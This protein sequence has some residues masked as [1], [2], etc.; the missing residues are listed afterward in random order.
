[1]RECPPQH[2]NSVFSFLAVAQLSVL[3]IFPH[4]CLRFPLSRKRHQC[5]KQRDSLELQDE[6][7][8]SPVWVFLGVKRDKLTFLT[9]TSNRLFPPRA[10]AMVAPKPSCTFSAQHQ[11]WWSLLR[12]GL[13]QGP[14]PSSVQLGVRRKLL[15]TAFPSLP[16]A[17]Q[18]CIPQTASC[19]LPRGWHRGGPTAELSKSSSEWLTMRLPLQGDGLPCKTSLLTCSLPQDRI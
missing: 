17:S 1:M 11:L 9:A 14:A 16:Y 10:L 13:W 18:D 7:A 8:P 15:P 2:W 6:C 4:S 19:R 3:G 5:P 12:Q